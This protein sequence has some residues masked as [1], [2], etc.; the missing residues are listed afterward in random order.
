MSAARRKVD[1][2]QGMLSALL[3]QEQQ[4]QQQQQGSQHLQGRP[5]AAVASFATTAAVDGKQ[6]ADEQ[7]QELRQQLTAAQVRGAPTRVVRFGRLLVAAA[8]LPSGLLLLLLL[9]LL[10]GGQDIHESPCS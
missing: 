6:G 10:L 9:Q 1:L 8:K 7:I 2:L 3:Q 5:A 4:Q